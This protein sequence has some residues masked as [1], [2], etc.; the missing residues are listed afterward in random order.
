MELR[1]CSVFL[2]DGPAICI[3]HAKITS[4]LGPFFGPGSKNLGGKLM[5]RAIYAVIFVALLGLA[6]LPSAAW[7]GSVTVQVGYADNLRPSPFFPTNFCNGGV[8]FDG[9]TGATCAQTFDAGAIRIVNNTGGV[10]TVS[11][12]SVQINASLTYSIW[13][14]GGAF[15]IADGTD[16]VLSQI[17]SYNFDSSDNGTGTAPGDGFDPIVTIVYTDPSVAGGA[18]QTLVL[19]DSG[20][21]LNTGGFDAVNGYNGTCLGFQNVVGVNYPG[22]CNESQ[23][24]RDI[25]TIGYQNPGGG[26][27]EPGTIVLLLTGGV[28]LFGFA[29]RYTA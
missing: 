28:S 29:R 3:G 8:Q 23:Q 12:V 26:A 25:G 10:M 24:W 2:A 27:P 18:T 4:A 6:L 16:E 21:V 20:Q 9:S 17:Y 13:N 11:S 1:L 7:A 5:K 14:T 22:S 19:T 15:T